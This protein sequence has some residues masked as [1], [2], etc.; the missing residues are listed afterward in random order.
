MQANA[1]ELSRS[2]V[3]EFTF[4]HRTPLSLTATMT[5][6]SSPFENGDALEKGHHNIPALASGLSLG[7]A[8]SSTSS[9]LGNDDAY[10]EKS[11]PVSPLLKTLD[12]LEVVPYH[13]PLELPILPE[14]A[15]L[16]KNIEVASI[17]SSLQRRH[18]A[19]L[20]G[21]P[22][23]LGKWVELQW[24]LTPYR[25]FISFK[26]SSRTSS[27]S[28]FMLLGKFYI[29]IV[30]LNLVGIILSATG[31]FAYGR[32][33]TGAILLGNLLMAVLM[34]NELFLRVLY[35]LTNTLLAKVSTRLSSLHSK[36]RAI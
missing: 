14:K 35:F 19:T 29:F 7:G 32:T 30:T 1:L 23:K 27:E 31:H 18:L 9:G 28:C 5:S 3:S 6:P 26:L 21:L 33:H 11:A 17:A 2:R 25:A 34:R 13:A 4:L 10:P 12:A 20:N 24:F 22:R 8:S 16:S 36:G 15:H